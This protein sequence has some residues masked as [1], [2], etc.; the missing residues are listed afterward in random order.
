V[1]DAE[2]LLIFP[3]NGNAIEAIDCLG[4]RYRLIA[5][6]DDTA[7]KQ[8]TTVH[9]F[10]VL[11]REGL[12]QHPTARLLAV[13]GSPIS[14]GRRRQV[15]EGLG[16][17]D[18]RFARVVHPRATVS[19]LARIGRNVLVMAGVVITSD[20]VI[21]DHVCILPNTVVHHDAVI[22][23]WSLIGA[24]VTIAGGVVVGEN[25]YVGSGST[26]I[27]GVELGSNCL[28]GLGSNVVRAV[29]PGVRV[30][31]NPARELLAKPVIN[32]SL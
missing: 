31:G 17:A 2:P 18:E 19:P 3:C 10:P 7:A 32:R 8:G 30:A 4:E 16:V 25:C 20:A 15:I 21:G 5:F 14:Y 9:G 13:P 22:G 12:T 24:S 27:N 23:A 1:P 6:I 29:A 28:V 11:G 26:V